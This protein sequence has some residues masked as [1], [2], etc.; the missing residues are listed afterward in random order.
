M[1]YQ[2]PGEEP[3]H[4]GGEAETKRRAVSVRAWTPT[5]MPISDEEYNKLSP[6]EQKTYEEAERKREREEQAG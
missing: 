5:T 6:E 2:A 4:G 3:R 1:M